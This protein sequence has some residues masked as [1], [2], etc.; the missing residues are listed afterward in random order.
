MMKTLSEININIKKMSA[1]SLR[2]KYKN[3]IF[4][5]FYERLLSL[6]ENYEINS[7]ADLYRLFNTACLDDN[8]QKIFAVKPPKLGW[9]D[10]YGQEILFTEDNKYEWSLNNIIKK[11]DT[12][13]GIKFLFNWIFDVEILK[14]PENITQEKYDWYNER[15]LFYERFNSTICALYYYLQDKNV[16]DINVSEVAKLMHAF[17]IKDLFYNNW[18]FADPNRKLNVEELRNCVPYEYL[19]PEE[20]EIYEDMV[21]TAFKEIKW[22]YDP[23]KILELIE[24][25]LRKQNDNKQN[26]EKVNENNI[27][28]EEIIDLQNNGE[29]NG[30]LN[31][32]PE[33]YRD[34][35][36]E[37]LNDIYNLIEKKQKIEQ[38]LEQYGEI[39]DI[40][41]GK[42]EESKTEEFVPQEIIEY[43]NDY[44]DDVTKGQDSSKKGIINWLK[45]KFNR[46]N[47]TM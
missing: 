14:K 45:N 15:D 30:L 26:Y 29:R 43:L 12:V 22:N 44:Q 39:V 37:F 2:L 9:D 46:N 3:E 41:Q 5:T 10:K 27:F 21:T 42:T 32:L 35:G 13:E 8:N 25:F 7:V 47:P 17:R 36:N 18:I 34:N 38:E 4:K 33:S 1:S 28:I 19:N 31:K 16:K 23:W 6:A 20:K 24:D 11:L 40:I